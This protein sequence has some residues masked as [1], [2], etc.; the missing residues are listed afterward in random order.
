MLSRQNEQVNVIQNISDK[1][2]SEAFE[3]TKLIIQY[4]YNAAQE[5][6]FYVLERIRREGVPEDRDFVRNE[7]RQIIER[8]YFKRKVEFESFSYDN[9]QL[10]SYI[11]AEWMERVINVFIDELYDENYCTEKAHL[12]I[13]NVYTEIKNEFYN[14]LKTQ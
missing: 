5:E 13:Q 11:N 1:V 8:I 6:V 7:V 9:K 14:R 4:A 12:N 10:S 2:D 3:R